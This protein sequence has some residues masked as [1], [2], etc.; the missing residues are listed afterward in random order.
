MVDGGDPS[1]DD[2]RIGRRPV[3]RSRTR[4]GGPGGR[5]WRMGAQTL[6]PSVP[7]LVQ[8]CPERPTQIPPQQQGADRDEADPAQHRRVRMRAARRQRPLGLDRHQTRPS[9]L[10]AGLVQ[11]RSGCCDGRCPPSRLVQGDQPRHPGLTRIRSQPGPPPA[12]DHPAPTPRL[13]SRCG[14]G[15]AETSAVRTVRGL[16]GQR[17]QWAHQEA[18]SAGRRRGRSRP[19]QKPTSSA[20]SSTASDPSRDGRPATELP[21]TP[22]EP[23]SPMPPC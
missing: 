12:T 22:P 2:H 18:L 9:Q 23:T 15:P 21:P 3:R 11:Q 6:G 10:A 16:T 5:F 13:Q 4:R 8:S 19:A 1:A 20:T 7:G 17:G 14:P